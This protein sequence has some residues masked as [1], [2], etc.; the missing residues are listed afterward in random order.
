MYEA[1][2]LYSPASLFCPQRADLRSPPKCLQITTFQQWEAVYL[3]PKTKSWTGRRR[4]QQLKFPAVSAPPPL[5]F[6]LPNNNTVR[7]T[8]NFQLFKPTAPL[9][10]HALEQSEFPESVKSNIGSHA[11][12][13][14]WG[15][16]VLLL[17]SAKHANRNNDIRRQL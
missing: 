13:L 12:S 11:S 1:C 14:R 4:S 16:P 9:V 10:T 17:K 3:Q 5:L 8:T 6:F 7:T 15:K 2:F